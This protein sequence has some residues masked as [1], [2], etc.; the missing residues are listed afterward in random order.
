MLWFQDWSFG[1]Q[2]FK[3]FPHKKN[4]Y[5]P[6]FIDSCI[7]SFLMNFSTPKVIV[8]NV[9][10]TNVFGKLLFL[11]SSLFQIW[12][13][14]QKLFTDKLTSCNLKI[15]LTSPILALW[16]IKSLVCRHS[17]LPFARCAVLNFKDFCFIM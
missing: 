2:S 13:K 4:N 5:P 12:K 17:T 8:Q 10:K 3:D 16:R 7:K 11:V 9:P 6:N 15:S 1:N 14:L